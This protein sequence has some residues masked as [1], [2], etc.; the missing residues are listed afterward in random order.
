MQDIYQKVCLER[1]L[2]ISIKE[3]GSNLDAILL[4]YLANQLEGKCNVEGYFKKA[5]IT[6]LSYSSGEIC[7]GS[8]IKFVVVFEAEV[9]L[10]VE[11]VV[12]PMTVLNIT[13]AGIRGKI[14][15]DTEGE[16]PVVIYIARDHFNNDPD[17]NA[18]TVDT[19]KQI[20]IKVIGHRYEINDDHI[21]V[22][23]ELL[24]DVKTIT[25]KQQTQ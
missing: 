24:K 2:Q 20:Y 14:K 10:P 9:C 18:I 3:I 12:F 13:K 7:N 11:G 25:V 15:M 4:T 21:Y 23:G 8:N 19:T 5:S 1:T 6:I 22:I 16:D 17:F